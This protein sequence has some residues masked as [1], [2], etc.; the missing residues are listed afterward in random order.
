MKFKILPKTEAYDRLMDLK[1]RMIA[2]N[3]EA[4]K[5]VEELGGS[6]YCNKQ[7]VAFGGIAAIKFAEK[8]KGWRIVGKT[9]QNL[10]FPKASEK[11]LLQKISNLPVIEYEEIN[12]IVKFKAPQTVSHENHLAW[13]SCV[14]LIWGKNYILIS[15]AP[16]AKYEP[17]KDII[18]IVESEY[19]KLKLKADQEKKSK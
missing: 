11:Q 13:V 1:K 6:E 18:E 12:N 16:G 15:V 17:P 19:E 7:H 2:V 14:G 10:Y 4:G 8:P 9:W 5:L 3:E